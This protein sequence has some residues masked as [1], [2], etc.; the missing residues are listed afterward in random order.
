VLVADEAVEAGGCLVVAD[1]EGAP[2]EDRRW[3][4]RSGEGVSQVDLTLASRWRSVILT[5]FDVE[6]N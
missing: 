4:P 5:L 2:V 3:Y 1:G 6:G